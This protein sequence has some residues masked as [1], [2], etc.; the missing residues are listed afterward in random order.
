VH[1]LTG[2]QSEYLDDMLWGDETPREPAR[3]LRRRRWRAREELRRL[4][5]DLDG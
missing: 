4:A 2:I 1:R 3:A 5:P